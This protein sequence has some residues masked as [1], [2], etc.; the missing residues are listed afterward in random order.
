MIDSLDVVAFRRTPWC[1]MSSGEQEHCVS[2]ALEQCPRSCHLAAKTI[3]R[4][5]HL[6]GCGGHTA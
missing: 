1:E 4:A 2:I 5:T 3:P 6:G